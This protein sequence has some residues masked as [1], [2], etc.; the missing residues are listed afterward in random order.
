MAGVFLGALLAL[1]LNVT[2]SWGDAA[3]GGIGGGTGRLSAAAVEAFHSPPHTCL[4]WAQPDASD[5]HKVECALPHLFEVTSEADLSSE[6]PEGAPVPSLEIWQQIS[7]A[8]CGEAVKTYL[9]R[10]LDP[11]GRLT[12][13]LLRPT[14]AQWDNG[15][16][17]LRCG[18]QWAGPAG[19]LQPTTGP[20]AEQQQ[21]MVWEPGTCLGLNGKS[22]GDPVDCGRPHSYEIITKLDLKSKFTD[23]YPSQ[24]DQKTWLDT[25]CSKAAGEYT[26]GADLTARNLILTWDL[27]EQESWDAGSTLVNCKVA[28]KLPDGTGLAS[29]TGSLKVAAGSVG[30]SPAA[31]PDAGQAPAP[32][33]TSKSG[34]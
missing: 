33:S 20:A 10:A 16:R 26:N 12:V 34:G 5:V 27:R 2:F 18:L 11:Y 19:G 8:R 25:E 15:D 9:G 14:A 6:Y 4:T 28:A 31:G 17:Q 3:Q 22:V 13:S 24:D 32:T 1:A 23:G 21:S 29:V 7:Q 30:D